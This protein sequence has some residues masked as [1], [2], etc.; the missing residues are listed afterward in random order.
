M[1]IIHVLTVLH[2]LTAGLTITGVVAIACQIFISDLL[3][4]SGFCCIFASM[5]CT[6]D[7]VI[8]TGLETMSAFFKAV[9]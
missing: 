3:I 6:Y 4:M 2:V 9:R 1:L 7:F 5:D 8:V